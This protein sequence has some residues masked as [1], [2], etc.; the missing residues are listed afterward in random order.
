MSPSRVGPKLLWIIHT[1]MLGKIMS[2]KNIKNDK[3][4]VGAKRVIKQ[5][6]GVTPADKVVLIYDEDTLEVQKALTQECEK[7]TGNIDLIKMEDLG[8]RGNPSKP[9]KWPSKLEQGFNNYTVSIYAAG[10]YAGELN[11][12][13]QPMLHNVVRHKVKHGHMIHITKRAMEEGFCTSLDKL[14]FFT[15][16]LYR[17]LIGCKQIKINSPAGTDLVCKFSSQYDWCIDDGL[18]IPGH[19]QNLPAGE[20]FTAPETVDGTLVI[21]GP[22][23]DYFSEFGL[24]G[25]KPLI[26]TIKDCK[27]VKVDCSRRKLKSMIVDYISKDKYSSYI[28]EIGFGTNLGLKELSGNL[29]QDEKFPGV[30]I[31][32]GDSYPELTGVKRPSKVHCDGI[33]TNTNVWVDNCQILKNGNYIKRAI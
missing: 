25:N 15:K 28:G 7:V 10:G 1:L 32:W 17:R 23:G 12:F 9:L 21:D 2:D 14:V 8:K 16:K 29:L 20:V 22:L 3:L 19:L 6:L 11:S 26:F 13:R 4:Q 5:S 30:H 24:L 33:T 27:I 18:V 31:A